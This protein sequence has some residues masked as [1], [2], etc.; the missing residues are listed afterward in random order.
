MLATVE[1]RKNHAML[2]DIWS[3]MESGSPHLVIIG[4]PGGMAE[5]SANVIERCRAMADRIRYLPRCRDDELAAWM[6]HALALLLPSFAEGFG[7]P[8]LEALSRGVPVIVSDLPTLR[9]IGG[10]VAEYV[11]PADAP[12]WEAVIRSYGSAA[13]PARRAQRERMR[14]FRAP[15][16]ETHFAA[17]E[18]LLERMDSPA[19][20]QVRS[21]SA[22]P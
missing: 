8:V 14:G 3:R 18:R 22:R 16:W 1:S 15:D 19:V 7:L 2:L 10:D 11:E 17:V 20:T 5:F 12:R 6:D 21:T 13:A 4:Q 9:E